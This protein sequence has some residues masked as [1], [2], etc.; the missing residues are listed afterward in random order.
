MKRLEQEGVQAAIEIQLSA[1]KVAEENKRLRRL[2]RHVGVHE[3]TINSWD[4]E[5][6]C[7]RSEVYGE[8][9]VNIEVSGQ[10]EDYGAGATA[11]A[12]LTEPDGCAVETL[13]PNCDSPARNENL[14]TVKD[15]SLFKN[16][17][18]IDSA[19]LSSDITP[20]VRKIYANHQYRSSS[21][22]GSNSSSIIPT[23]SAPCKRNCNSPARKGDSGNV[24]DFPLSKNIESINSA[25]LLSDITPDDRK[26]YANHQHRISSVDLPKSS[27]TIPTPSAPCKLL[28]HLTVN[29]AADIT[30]MPLAPDDREGN[31][32][33]DDGIPCARAYQMLIHYATSEP[34]L[35]AVAGILEEGCVPNEGPGGGCRV[36]SKTIMKALD[37]ICL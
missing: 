15:S 28:S 6:P 1:R 34:K 37:D 26:T 22:D 30:Q 12:A 5:R 29:P 33:V 31:I 27:G 19:S 35:D 36:R 13:P 14:G 24:K 32:V 9:V 18:L 16:G 8:A 10:V 2:L 20:D 21:P 17:E 25:S 11:P 3:E 23:P 7:L 4:S